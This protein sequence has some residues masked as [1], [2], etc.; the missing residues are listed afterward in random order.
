MPE[1]IITNFLVKENNIQSGLTVGVRNGTVFE[2][3]V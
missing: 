2:N 3:L 1:I